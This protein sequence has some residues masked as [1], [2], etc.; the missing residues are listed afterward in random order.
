MEKEPV[1]FSIP[2]ER[3]RNVA[4]AA[5]NDDLILSTAFS[6]RGIFRIHSGLLHE[7]R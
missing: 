4:V 3:E 5:T 7:K 2:S 1:F 6:F